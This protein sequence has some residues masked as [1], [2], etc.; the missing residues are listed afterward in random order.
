MEGQIIARGSLS[1]SVISGTTG[2]RY[3]FL[4]DDEPTE[5]YQVQ[6]FALAL[7]QSREPQDW[8][9][10]FSDYPAARILDAQIRQAAKL[11]L[12]EIY[13]RGIAFPEAAVPESSDFGPPNV[14][15]ENRYNEAGQRALYL[16]KT[17]ATVVEETS[18]PE[19]QDLF[20]QKFALAF[21]DVKVLVLD[22]DMETTFPHLHC[23]LLYAERIPLEAEQLE[24]SPSSPFPQ[25]YKVG[26][27]IRH[28]C[29][30]HSIVAVQYPSVRGGYKARAD[31][32]NLA[33]FGS[34]INQVLTM[35]RGDPLRVSR[36]EG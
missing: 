31:A 15:E 12:Q 3:P 21:A 20:V 29:D 5:C 7:C 6:E 36:R 10:I 30:S 25:P 1:I 11:G 33:L 8:T 23:L 13:Y 14:Q 35:T 28:V 24:Q 16:A 18:P 27:F 17:L 2:R 9:A 22:E 4:R 32:V 34:T 19:G 26:H